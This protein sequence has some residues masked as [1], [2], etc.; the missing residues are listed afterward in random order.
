MDALKERIDEH[1]KIKDLGHTIYLLADYVLRSNMFLKTGD[2]WQFKIAREDLEK[3]RKYM[4]GKKGVIYD[5]VYKAIELGELL[6][7]LEQKG[8]CKYAKECWIT[9]KGFAECRKQ[10]KR[11]G[12][13]KCS[14]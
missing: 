8:G 10:Q 7:C 4:N 12:R 5:N 2:D 6:M 13:K 11:K 9:R 3:L 14:L 1:L